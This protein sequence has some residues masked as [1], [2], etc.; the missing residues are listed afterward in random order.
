MTIYSYL[1]KI[2]QNYDSEKRGRLLSKAIGKAN[3][4]D[5]PSLNNYWANLAINLLDDPNI[6][7]H[8][9]PIRDV[10]QSLENGNIE[11]ATKLY[12]NP[13]NKEIYNRVNEM[14]NELFHLAQEDTHALAQVDEA[15]HL[16]DTIAF[17]AEVID[18]K[19]YKYSIQYI[20]T[21]ILQHWT[22]KIPSD[23]MLH[24]T[25]VEEI[26]N[27]I[28]L[29]NFH[30]KESVMQMLPCFKKLTPTTK[31]SS[32]HGMVMHQKLHNQNLLS[33]FS[34]DIIKNKN[35]KINIALTLGLNKI[36]F[37]ELQNQD[38]S[39]TFDEYD[40]TLEISSAMNKTMYHIYNSIKN[41]K[42]IKNYPKNL[43]EK[44][45]SNKSVSFSDPLDDFG[46]ASIR[47]PKDLRHVHIDSTPFFVNEKILNVNYG[48]I[49][50]YFRDG[51]MNKLHEEL[52]DTL[53]QSSLELHDTR[54]LASS[55]IRSFSMRSKWYN[56]SVFSKSFESAVKSFTTTSSQFK[57]IVSKRYKWSE[58]DN[59]AS[60]T[61]AFNKTDSMR[62][63]YETSVLKWFN[64]GS[65]TKKSK[66]AVTGD[67][68]QLESTTKNPTSSYDVD[69][70]NLDST[71]DQSYSANQLSVVDETNKLN[72]KD[73]Q[74]NRTMV[75]TFDQSDEDTC[76]SM[77][78]NSDN[79][80]TFVQDID[81]NFGSNLSQ[82][83][84]HN[85]ID[86]NA[87]MIITGDEIG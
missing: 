62:K 22:E 61:V 69:V 65:F 16:L 36:L 43:A 63:W 25:I 39:S 2:Y 51:S 37:T 85:S 80:E 28:L 5:N 27:F 45:L 66:I 50:Q 68:D 75:L 14:I 10:I 78:K 40:N 1:H 84:T 60:Q 47:N 12:L 57:D 29:Q 64:E 87:T 11:I 33:N 83:E 79:I 26:L 48:Q 13:D 15:N 35:G 41:F 55:Q 32:S 9:V 53:Q 7:R 17:M 52:S 8:Y 71:C 38:M 34:S 42:T 23:T 4:E 54:D 76:K 21:F 3:K 59:S 49:E 74:N 86:H 31:L 70:E 6:P 67:T 20:K 30:T 56:T 72:L 81:N 46:L 24:T 73:L 82:S 18:L 19:G 58:S 77:V 44:P